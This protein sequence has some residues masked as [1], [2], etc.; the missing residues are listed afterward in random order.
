ML[1]NIYKYLLWFA[2]ILEYDEQP[3]E[4]GHSFKPLAF[5][6]SI[7]K[8]L[9]LFHVL[10]TKT[11]SISVKFVDKRLVSFC[12][13]SMIL[14]FDQCPHST[15]TSGSPAR[16][17]HTTVQASVASDAIQQT[18]SLRTHEGAE[19]VELKRARNTD[20]TK[21]SSFL[22]SSSTIEGS[23]R[24]RREERILNFPISKLP[25][26]EAILTLA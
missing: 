16:L 3:E 20:F 5:A 13:C 22:R 10:L 18:N 19:F 7:G 11:C 12:L 25:G 1:T 26:A 14:S 23:Q 2:V 15:R 21:Y 6:T 17:N 9:Y 24:G 8:F 4:S